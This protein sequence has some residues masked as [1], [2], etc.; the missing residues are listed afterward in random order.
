MR[1]K[2]ICSAV[3]GLALV[4]TFGAVSAHAAAGDAGCVAVGGTS[5]SSC[6]FTSNGSAQSGDVAVS[7]GC[8]ITHVDATGA[9]VTDDSGT[10]PAGGNF[11][12][13]AGALY[14]VTVSGN[15]TVVVTPV[16]PTS[17]T[18]TA[19]REGA[20]SDRASS[21][22]LNLS[23]R[24]ISVASQSG[25]PLGQGLCGRCLG[26]SRAFGR[27][28]GCPWRGVTSSQC[29]ALPV[30]A[31][32]IGLTVKTRHG[33]HARRQVAWRRRGARSHVWSR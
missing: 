23:R 8:S 5:M 32:G 14:T 31:G 28:G 30:P 17:K 9:T 33:L 11:P 12:F 15:G 19:V 26:P 21:R 22:V 10:K 27:T 3:G 24:R 7:N 20:R 29:R 6:Q 2:L 4:T 25:N 16:A 13:V 1:P 18:A